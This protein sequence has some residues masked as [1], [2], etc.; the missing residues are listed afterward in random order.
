MGVRLLL[1]DRQLAPAK[2]QAGSVHLSS[3]RRT[4]SRPILICNAGSCDCLHL[5][6][7]IC[8]LFLFTCCLISAE[9][10]TEVHHHRA[11]ASLQNI[12]LQM[13]HLCRKTSSNHNILLRNQSDS[14]SVSHQCCLRGINHLFGSWEGSM[15]LRTAQMIHVS[16]RFF[17]W[18]LCQQTQE[19]RL[20][21]RKSMESFW[22]WS[23]YKWCVH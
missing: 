4:R 22:N 16:T 18:S 3:A 17:T 9:W 21:N 8:T 12:Q 19:Q 2:V 15:K 20:Q 5:Y 11:E 23:N 7:W 13:L 10:M 14:V 1:A 6:A